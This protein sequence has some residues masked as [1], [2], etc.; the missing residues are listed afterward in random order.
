VPECASD[1]LG[2]LSFGST[3]PLWSEGK[4][5]D[6]ERRQETVGEQSREKECQIRGPNLLTDQRIR[7]LAAMAQRLIRMLGVQPMRATRSSSPVAVVVRLPVRTDM[8]CGV[9]VC[10]RG[11][12]VGRHGRT[13]R[14]V[15]RKQPQSEHRHTCEQQQ[16]R[17]Q[18]HSQTCTG[19]HVPHHSRAF[20]PDQTHMRV[21]L[22][23]PSG[24]ILSAR[25][26]DTRAIW[27]NP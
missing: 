13:R 11:G 5:G 6:D 10:G 17:S 14:R 21:A 16:N 24:L 20:G 23:T 19:S 4:P 1:G 3:R 22:P 12:F 27:R 8:M 9:R 2:S 18:A 25:K 7:R 15:R 26:N